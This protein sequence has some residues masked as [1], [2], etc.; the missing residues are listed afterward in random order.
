MANKLVQDDDMN[1]VCY[2]YDGH[3]ES[4]MTKEQMDKIAIDSG[5]DIEQKGAYEFVKN[6]LIEFDRQHYVVHNVS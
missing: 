1:V 4:V 5:F 2:D 3:I 6:L